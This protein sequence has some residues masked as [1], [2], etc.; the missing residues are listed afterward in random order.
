MS[1]SAD[2]F[3][4]KLRDYKN[5]LEKIK[6][7]YKLGSKDNSLTNEKKGNLKYTLQ[8]LKNDLS[9]FKNE[10]MDSNYRTVLSEFEDSNR[11]EELND[12]IS[13]IDTIINT[14]C[15]GDSIINI[16]EEDYKDKEFDNPY[17]Q[18]QYQKKKLL[19]QDEL[20]NQMISTNKESKGIGREVKKNLNEQNK[21]INKIGSVL[22]KTQ[23]EANKLND[24]FV[25]IVIDSSFWKLYFIIGF[26]ALVLI[27]LWL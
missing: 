27:W 15:K 22:D 16:K 18:L 23:N 7:E 14:Y 6:S 10:Y 24:K 3:K 21:K 8:K 13:H 5:N 12:L 2:N 9:N 17:E 19:E 25:Y 1:K 26:L 11:R 20:I 4:S